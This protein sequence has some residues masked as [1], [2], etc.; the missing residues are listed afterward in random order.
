MPVFTGKLTSHQIFRTFYK[1]FS[2]L[3]LLPLS[4]RAAE[5]GITVT[6]AKITA[7][8]VRMPAPVYIYV[9]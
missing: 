5:A 6:E 8:W 7:V 1:A 2:E 9:C 3:P 4:D